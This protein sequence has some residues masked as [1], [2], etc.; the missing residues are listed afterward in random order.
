MAPL[1]TN[2]V[3]D[4]SWFR[5]SADGLFRPP[6]LLA[7][8]SANYHMEMAVPGNQRTEHE[9]TVQLP[10]AGLDDSAAG[11]CD[12]L[13]DLQAKLACVSN[14]VAPRDLDGDSD[15]VAARRRLVESQLRAPE[16]A[17]KGLAFMEACRGCVSSCNMGKRPEKD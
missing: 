17:G 8:G 12:A 16:S 15:R 3:T 1:E 14:P 7:E 9:R 5:I 4:R 11:D 6:S 13:A 2:L 10:P